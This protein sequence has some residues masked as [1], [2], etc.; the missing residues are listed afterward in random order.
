MKKYITTILVIL[1]LCA[2]VLMPNDINASTASTKH[3]I[4]LEWIGNNNKQ[5]SGVI[6]VI[7]ELNTNAN[8]KRIQKQ[9][10]A[11]KGSSIRREY[12][13]VL[14]G[15]S[16]EIPANSLPAI[17]N[18]VGVKN[19]SRTVQYQELMAS[20]KLITQA[21]EASGK[22]GNNGEGVVVSI[23]DSGIDVE[24][25]AL[26][27]LDNPKLAKIQDIQP[28]GGENKD[29]HFN[30]KVPYGYNFADNSYYVKG[31]ES[32]HGVHVAGIV[33]ANDSEEKINKNEGIDGVAS[34]AQLLAMKVFSN[35]PKGGGA[36]DDDIIAAIEASV[37]HQA[38]IINL[39][40]GTESGFMNNDNPMQRAINAAEEKGVLVVAAAGNDT[41]AFAKSTEGAEIENYFNRKDNGIVGSPST[42]KGAL[43][44]ASFENT[45][46]FAYYLRYQTQ[47]QNKELIY[48]YTQGE[49]PNEAVKFAYVKEG[50]EKDYINDVRGK[51]LLIQ[52]GTSTFTEKVKL[53]KKKGAIGAIIFNNKENEE[54][55]MNLTGAPKNY[56]A[57]SITKED[58][59]MLVKLIEK[60][61]IAFNF[62]AM[63]KQVDNKFKAKMSN[64]TSI[65][66][67]S[68][69]DFK[70]EIT[71][72]GGHVYSTDNDNKYVMM[73]GTS[74][75]SPHVA[76]VSAIV[77]SELKKALP[78]IE[79]HAN[80]TKKTLI[81]TAK[82]IYPENSDLPYSIRRQGSGLVQTK[83]AIENRV[84]ATM[85]D[86]NGNA[87][88]ELR[89]FNNQ[90][91]F[92]VYLHN[93]GDDT[94][95]FNV[96]PSHVYTTIS[97]DN[98]LKEAISKA[99]IHSTTKNI[100][101][102][103]K[104]GKTITFT[105]DAKNVVDDFVE[106]FI[107][108]KS[109]TKGQPNIHFAYMGFVGD[110]NKE[111]IFDVPDTV[112][113][114]G[115]TIFSD[116]QLISMVKN[117]LDIFDQGKIFT[118]GIPFGTTDKTLNP[119]EKAVAFSPNGDG[120]ADIVLPQIG[121]LRSAKDMEINI[122]DA[123]KQN[124]KHLYE[125]EGVRRQSYQNYL[126]RIAKKQQFLVYPYA[127]GIWDGM[128]FDKK[129]GKNE[130]L[131]D[132]QYYMQVKARLS[133]DYD[134]QELLFPIRIDRKAPKIEIIKA[135][136]NDYEITNEGRLLTF[137]VTDETAVG[138]VYV[139]V[140]GTRIKA[141]K[142]ND[143]T[144]KVLIPF[145]NKMDESVTIY[146]NDT[147]LNESKKTIE[148]LGGNTLELTNWEPYI[149]KK[150]NTKMGQ[151]VTGLTKN[152]E[153]KNIS[154]RFINKKTGEIID[155]KDNPVY[156]GGKILFASYVL[157]KQGKYTAYAIEKNAKKEVI[158][159]TS[160]GDYVYDYTPP[161]VL[162]FNSVEVIKDKALQKNPLKDLSKDY[163]EYVMRL[164]PDGS[165]TFKGKVSDN[166]FEPSELTMS[167]GGRNNKVMIDDEGNFEYTL[168]TP[169]NMFDFV[170]VSQPLNL[171]GE[172]EK[173]SI[174]DSLDLATDPNAN[175]GKKRVEKTLTV[176]KYLE[177]LE[178]P[179]EKEFA[180]ILNKTFVLGKASVNS[181]EANAVIQRGDQYFFK[182][183]G[184]TNQLNNV[185][186]VQ[187]EV[188]KTNTT[189][190]KGTHF[191]KEV[192]IHEG[193][194][195]INVRVN[196]ENGE[197]LAD[198]KVR[199]LF[200]LSLP[201]MVLEAPTQEKMVEGEI[202]NDKNEIEK[203]I[204]LETYEDN[205]IFK[206]S[207]SDAG[208]GYLLK[209][210]D[211]YVV[212]HSGLDHIEGSS[213]HGNNTKT[214]E[215]VIA[216]E[217]QDIIVLHLE[218]TNDNKHDL[219]YI[220]RK[221]ERPIKEV[222]FKVK[223]ANGNDLHNWVANV[224]QDDEVFELKDNL[225]K[226]PVGDYHYHLSEMVEGFKAIQD[227][228]F[229]V[230]ED[231]LE[232]INANGNEI[233]VKDHTLIIYAKKIEVDNTLKTHVD[234]VEYNLNGYNTESYHIYFT[235]NN[236]QVVKPNN[237]HEVI[238]NL[239]NIDLDNLV[240]FKLNSK[241]QHIKI[242]DYLLKDNA[243]ILRDKDFGTYIFANKVVNKQD[244][245]TIDL[246][247]DNGDVYEYV[248]SIGPE[249]A[250]VQHN[251]KTTAKNKV[252][253][254]EKTNVD[255]KLKPS[256]IKETK[257][258]DHSLV[259]EIIV[260]SSAVLCF[261]ILVLLKKRKNQNKQ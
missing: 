97:K 212:D 157:T 44:V 202:T 113:N 253:K 87:V 230:K 145:G 78:T 159:E 28:Y 125:I 207:I 211:E 261:I 144:Y 137:K 102:K 184:F 185:I 162:E 241:G 39:S 195:A 45:N 258:S 85:E 139:K 10:L 177:A 51:V 219:K 13:V 221:V 20:S 232:V 110:W 54:L 183:D 187:N 213:K 32:N 197:M 128:V 138:V 80:F 254:E 30:I 243:L 22:Y 55:N 33:G 199:I 186:L 38:D 52:R 112:E 260:L 43:S 42:A 206:G 131:K 172:A 132:G 170:N 216:V 11:Y 242:S 7:V 174:I 223:D 191:E 15:F 249:Q 171:S 140:N 48:K 58:G 18:I 214:F 158:K 259:I 129:T 46:S 26:K 120:F 98:T 222:G 166:V 88:G 226:L 73:S 252:V 251:T 151:S 167:I 176:V 119:S 103:A 74:M 217:D 14:N 227:I 118:L 109:N 95:N 247:F 41:A 90:K 64:F 63:A 100:Q 49:I 35:D 83:D 193:S 123:N 53:A 179:E 136:A 36:H 104:E 67:T 29:T 244:I 114:Q 141:D 218:D 59:E 165:A 142:I 24:H 250:L 255:N 86:K 34:Q 72:V 147:A 61:D 62:D 107:E 234:Q 69:L 181:N 117:P 256:D 173:P 238:I 4:P 108:F 164:N 37:E 237:A 135:G 149:Q 93:Y 178:A 91:V 189:I 205:V 233:E 121:M 82:I 106:G 200:D 161:K 248:T 215:K 1:M 84:L 96:E 148:K 198:V 12:D 169:S 66:T 130:S 50:L 99:N 208:F 101:L 154:F 182:I 180:L 3:D 156:P 116:T 94:V 210:N 2:S 9:V 56:F 196:D 40:L 235:D 19:V 209:I 204:Y 79:N 31:L 71:G 21:L 65:G 68:S 134:Y 160:L 76:G 220:I 17:R 228:N 150:I 225:V 6:R 236:G 257:T 146:A 105:L 75:A 77:F 152:L 143:D 246:S 81:N 229:R 203:V 25:Q 5:D 124:I 127:E 111:S 153:T 239:K 16:A 122:L 8:M 27:T 201:T 194:N 60:E 23:I 231:G 70:P 188:A 192:E 92:N 133:E 115:K 57:G 175:Q 47:G 245:D 89:S 168:K 224:Y 163:V 190:D 126:G 155:T 240:V